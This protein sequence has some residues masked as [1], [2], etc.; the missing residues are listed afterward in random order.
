[1]LFQNV[2]SEIVN[3]GIFHGNKITSFIFLP[4][5]GSYT[6]FTNKGKL[7]D[8]DNS[9]VLE[10]KYVNNEIVITSLDIDYGSFKKVNFIGTSFQNSFK[11]KTPSSKKINIYEDN[12]IVSLHDYYN[13][14][15]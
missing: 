13:Y 15:Q 9:E 12:L 11:I 8:I 3:I 10:L 1:M 2:Y 4:E 6:V 7:L 14:I 5:E